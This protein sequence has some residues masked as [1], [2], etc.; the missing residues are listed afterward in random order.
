MAYG[1]TTSS[2]ERDQELQ[3]LEGREKADVAYEAKL[4]TARTLGELQRSMN[5]DVRNVLAEDSE[6]KARMEELSQ[7]VAKVVAAGNTDIKIDASLEGT[8]VQGYNEGLSSNTAISTDPLN[9]QAIT[10]DT[11]NA[12]II[13]AHERSKEVGHAGQSD[14]VRTLVDTD[15]SQVKVA[16][17]L[18]GNVENKTEEKYGARDGMPHAVYG[19]GKGFVERVGAAK[20]NSYVRKGGSMEGDHIGIQAHILERS[21]MPPDEMRHKL[22]QAGFVSQEVSQIVQRVRGRAAHL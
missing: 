22:H 3:G 9:A 6:A 14:K 2:A 19:E 13:A 18:E 5:A 8:T 12:V 17:T 7:S 15:G 1:T 21:S 16:T 4:R 20:I 10:Q 11:Q